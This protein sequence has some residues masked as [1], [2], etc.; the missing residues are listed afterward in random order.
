MSPRNVPNSSNNNPAQI[1]LLIFIVI[2]S[3]HLGYAMGLADREDNLQQ[4][5]NEQKIEQK[6]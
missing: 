3:A 6:K 4:Q 1:Y 5:K 2:L